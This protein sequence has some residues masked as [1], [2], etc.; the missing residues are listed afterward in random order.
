LH[1]LLAKAHLLEVARD[2]VD[3]LLV[4]EPV[5]RTGV[6][7]DAVLGVLGLPGPGHGVA[8]RMAD[9]G[10][11]RQ[12][13]LVSKLEVALVVGGHRHDRAFAVAHEH[14]VRDP[15]RQLFPGERVRHLEAGGHALLL[16]LRELGLHRRAAP[17]FFDERCDLGICFCYRQCNGMLGGNR[18]ESRAH[19]RI[20]AGGEDP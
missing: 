16:D 19:Q 14:V 15:H 17:A 8:E 10:L 12:A 11:D 6:D 18:A 5:V 2:R 3:R 4:R 7:A 1:L 13:V 9:H 20:G